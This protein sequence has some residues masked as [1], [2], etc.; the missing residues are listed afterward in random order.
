MVAQG[1][2]LI[3]QTQWLKC[4]IYVGCKSK[5][6]KCTILPHTECLSGV[7]PLY[8][9][10]VTYFL[11]DSKVP[12]SP[13]SL[14]ILNW[15][16]LARTESSALVDQILLF[17]KFALHL[18]SID[19]AEL[20]VWQEAESHKRLANSKRNEI[21]LSI[22]HILSISD[23]ACLSLAWKIQSSLLP[24]LKY[25]F[26]ILHLTF[27]FFYNRVYFPSGNLINVLIWHVLLLY[28]TE[29]QCNWQRTL[30]NVKKF[31]CTALTNWKVYL[32]SGKTSQSNNAGV[33]L[34]TL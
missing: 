32:G 16:R 12:S 25:I 23:F 33:F 20:G 34:P 11:L 29:L 5:N 8:A 31:K 18:P 6:E 1:V 7:D 14:I 4:T 26:L 17:Y 2:T 24:P 22:L 28:L 27:V 30:W 3:L 10:M 19:H 15:A 9:I 13:H 21:E